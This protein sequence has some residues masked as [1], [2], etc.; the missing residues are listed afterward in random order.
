V[1]YRERFDDMGSTYFIVDAHC[2]GGSM[3]ATDARLERVPGSEARWVLERLF[4][5][6]PLRLARTL[7]V[8][9][10]AHPPGLGAC[11]LRSI[12]NPEALLDQLL[13]AFGLETWDQ[14][15]N[16]FDFA[17]FHLLRERLGER[18][19]PRQAKSAEGQKLDAALARWGKQPFIHGGETYRVDR[20]G[21]GHD[22]ARDREAYETMSEDQLL[23]L[24]RALTTDPT[25]AA[26]R[27]AAAAE[28]LVAAEAQR[29]RAGSTDL[30]LVRRQR[31]YA[32]PKPEDRPIT[33]A[34]LRG[35]RERH[36]IEVAT[37]YP[38]G[39]PA[40]GVALELR[41]ADGATRAV[42]T[43][44]EG[45]A[46]LE[47]VPAGNVTIRL[48]KLDG[49]AWRALTGEAAR[50]SQDGAGI[51]WHRVVQGECLSKIARRRGL[52]AWQRIWDH[53]SNAALRKRRKSPHVLLP[54]DMLAVPDVT[55]HEIERATDATHRIEIAQ[56]AEMELQL[57]LHD[58]R[59]KG[60]DALTYKI[61]FSDPGQDV[62]RPGAG[63]T[64]RD[65]LITE[66]I[67]VGVDAV[68]IALDRPKLSFRFAVGQLDPLRDEDSLQ[69]V[70]SGIDARLGGLGFGSIADAATRREVLASFQRQHLDR[71]QADGSLDEATAQKLSDM[72]G[73]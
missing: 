2:V 40:V 65:G 32:R 56:Q 68:V 24:L 54:G 59:Q 37:A 47:P 3:H 5:C 67:P 22:P 1:F 45:F 73:V 6:E 39:K 70:P 12:P 49:D 51:H 71:E 4:R 8:V 30:F 34:Q 53:P 44:A 27:Q 11:T 36:W 9:T 66:R 64:G 48:P 13:R 43:D 21:E 38:D 58:G 41:L 15:T 42:S 19:V 33:P 29:A 26:D 61:A 20:A 10:E 14:P 7:E 62:V 60:L 16:G 31:F 50:P 23:A 55:L 63:P 28:L 69:A 25:L 18:V 46:R 72:Y 52:P 57:R 17:R 35:A